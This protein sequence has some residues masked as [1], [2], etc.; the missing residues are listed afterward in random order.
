MN[1]SISEADFERELRNLM[2][3]LHPEMAL[4][5]T[6]FSAGLAY[7]AR[8][9]ATGIVA[10]IDRAASD[11]RRADFMRAQLAAI[12]TTRLTHEDALRILEQHGCTVTDEV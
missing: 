8:Y 1:E 11:V 4:T 10:A 3:R 5:S 7:A 2:A 6:E 9:H 12:P